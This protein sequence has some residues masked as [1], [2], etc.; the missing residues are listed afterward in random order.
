LGKSH[1][2]EEFLQQHFTGMSGGSVGASSASSPCVLAIEDIFIDEGG[3]RTV[4][5]AEA[6]GFG[7]TMVRKLLGQL[8]AQGPLQ[9]VRRKVETLDGRQTTVRAYRLL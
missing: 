8:K 1:R 2:N 3:V 4:E 7:E 5:I 9:V 6:L